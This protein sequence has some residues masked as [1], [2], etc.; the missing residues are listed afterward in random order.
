MRTLILFS[1]FIIAVPAIGIASPVTMTEVVLK[2]ESYLEEKC[3]DVRTPVCQCEV[4]IS[5]YRFSGLKNINQI[6]SIVKK[7]ADRSVK[8]ASGL[9]GCRG[10]IVDKLADLPTSSMEFRASKYFENNDLLLVSYGA[11]FYGIGAA[12]PNTVNDGIIIFDKHLGKILTNADIFSVD[13]LGALNDYILKQLKK[14]PDWY[15]PWD[16]KYLSVISKEEAIGEIYIRGN[17]LKININPSYPVNIEVEIPLEFIA[18]PAIRE[19][20]KEPA[21]AR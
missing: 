14:D 4:D 9:L 6:N 21:N 12:H 19:L 20:Y 11:G 13:N 16:E 8:L 10:K 15:D 2:R 1:L 18:H 5:Y 17:R 3:D 7:N